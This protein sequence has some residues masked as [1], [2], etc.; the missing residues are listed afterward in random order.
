MIKLGIQ[1]IIFEACIKEFFEAIHRNRKP[2]RSRLS[3][4]HRKQS[5]YNTYDPHK[6]SISFSDGKTVIPIRGLRGLNSSII[7]P[8]DECWR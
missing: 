2:Q 7:Y 4:T 8:G 1:H 5:G 3:Y 6:V